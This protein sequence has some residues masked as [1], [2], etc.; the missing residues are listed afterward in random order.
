MSF[1]DYTKLPLDPAATPVNTAADWAGAAKAEAGPTAIADTK[2]VEQIPLKPVYGPS[3]LRDVSHLG[4]TA[5]IA[6][7]LRGPY[8]TMYV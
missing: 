8:A 3:D 5:G 6:P 2:T 7:Y 1:P 4:F